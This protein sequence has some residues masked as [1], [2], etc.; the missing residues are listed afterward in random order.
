MFASETHP[1]GTDVSSA[2]D[3]AGRLLVATPAMT[4]PRF[5]RAVVLI[6]AHDED[7]AMGVIVNRPIDDMSFPDLLDKLSVD[8]SAPPDPND[9]IILR[10]GGPVE[11]G[12][13]F[14]IHTDDYT[15][16][17]TAGAGAPGVSMTATVDVLRA[18]CSGAG[19]SRSIIALGYAGW[20]EG[21][22]EQELTTDAWIPCPSDPEIIF[23]DR[24]DNKWAQAIRL[25]GADPAAL[26]CG[27]SA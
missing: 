7:G 3:L 19:P 26:S 2:A 24:H 27:G 1:P 8:F 20:G 17:D 5:A 21:Q 11:R 13:G 14:V 22:L 25:V 15:G 6:C 4:D 12:R 9:A 18:I 16:G 10:A 23:S